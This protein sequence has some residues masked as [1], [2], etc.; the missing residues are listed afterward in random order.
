MRKL[1]LSLALLCLTMALLATGRAQ[2]APPRGDW[3]QLQEQLKKSKVEPGTALERLILDNQ[4]FH[5]LRAE[6]ASDKNPVPLW[7]R[8]WWRKNHPEA[9]Y[10]AADPTGGYPLVL[11]EVHE[12]MMTHQDLR[13]GTPEWPA[14]PSQKVATGGTNARISGAQTVPRSESDIRVNFQNPLLI[15]GAS[16]NIG[17]S[18]QQAQFFSSDGGATWGQTSLPLVTGDSF[19]SD[20][21]VEWTSDGTAWA[22]TIGINSTGSVLHMRA[23]KSIN[24]GQTWTFDNTFS[25]TQ[26]NTDKQLIWV[27]HSATSSFK[28]NLYACWHNGAPQFVNRR[29][30]PAGAWQTPLQISGAE[31]TGTAIGCDVTTNSA[32]DVF[33][34]WPSTGNSRVIVAKSTNGAVSFGTPVI[35]STTFGSFDIGVPSFNSRRALIYSSLG[36]VKSGTKNNVYIAW[37]DLS[38]ATGCTAPANEPGSS[39][40]STCKTRI[41]FARSTD[42]GATW[43]A[44]VKLNDQAS[45]NDQFNQRLVVD[46][47]TGQLAVMYYDTV[48]NS[49]RLKA[50]VYYQSSFDDGVTWSTALKVTSAMTDETIAGADSGNQYG[51]YNGLSGI[52]GTF[53]PSWTDR[54]S[55]AKEE[56]WTAGV[57]EGGGGGCTPPAA[58]TG[59]TVTA[60][61]QTGI[62]LSWTAVS[63]ATE[64]HVLRS[65]TSGGP[66]T[67]VGTATTTSFAD[68]GLTCNTTYFYVVRAAN[69]ATCESGNSAQA[70]ATT[71]ACSGGGNQVLTFSSSPALAIPDNNTTGVTST[72][73]VPDSMT[74]TSVSV[75]VGI[76]HTFQGDLE[77]AL[78]GPDNTTV[79]LHNRTGGGTDNINTTYNITTRSAQALTAFNG[80]NT[81]GAWKLRVRDLAAADTGT[82]NSWKVTFN[83]YSTLTAN[84]AIPDNNTTGITST[85]NVA[86][87]GTIV[88]L[89][90]RVDITHTFQGDLEVSLIGPDNTTVL[91]HNRTGGS[92]DNIQTVYADLT[93][94]AQSLS[95]FTGKAI[96]GAWKLR[97]RDLAAVDT[98]TLNF[99]EI[100]F[101]T[102]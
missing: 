57:V 89:R 7:L 73:N 42:G 81:A 28:D 101:R 5:M 40:T 91:L 60:S 63:G 58:P 69:S 31:T 62:N 44:K 66:Y 92:A 82:L 29:T 100:D 68:S 1:H 77:V 93:A 9:T 55:G 80:K 18:G 52:D 54:R 20:P 8:V 50:D 21:T 56:I 4:D 74:L 47:N 102:N 88:S 94:P 3:P 23:Y 48:A 24:N 14:A 65:T 30:G 17:G 32:G 59:L 37:T 83:G 19:H 35:A 11:R 72:I 25:G 2:A 64:Y 38:G 6:E 75:N 51:D 49:G 27:D 95:A 85:I 15:I 86:A 96:N 61:G 16:N 46:P 36:A 99:W 12:W 43:S 22:T 34:V 98:G 53:F 78:I 39:V 76:T 84:T 45:L 79:L 13:P 97:V 87:T 67:Q 41:W 33:V 26:S 10:S 70:T 71:N 90:V